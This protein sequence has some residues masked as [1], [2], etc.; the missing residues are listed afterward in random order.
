MIKATVIAGV[1]FTIGNVIWPVFD[2]P[3]LFY[4]P[5]AV[6]ITLLIVMLKK[7]VQTNSKCIHLIVN[8]LLL[9]SYGNIV[10]Q[11]LYT[12]EIAQ[13]NDYI[14]GGLVTI[15]LLINLVKVKKWAITTNQPHG[16]K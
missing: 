7:N 9:L 14:W 5:L 6:F 1:C 8:Y 3:K 11:V 16:R 2:E 10:K 12:D 13:V 4:V 15:W